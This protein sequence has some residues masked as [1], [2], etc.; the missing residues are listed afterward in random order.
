MAKRRTWWTRDFKLAAIGRMDAAANHAALAAE[1]G[2]GRGMLLKWRRA[3]ETGGAA[4]LNVPGQRAASAAAQRPP[5]APRD[6]L[7]PDALA[8]AR[9]RIAELER[10]IGQQQ[11]D[12]DFFR[13]ALR[14]V[15]ERRLKSGEPGETPST[16]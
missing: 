9:R 14:H 8:A 6:D 16:R 12:L 11:L 5:A 3:Y 10:T 2:V 15:R 7:P 1:L 4:A 13:A